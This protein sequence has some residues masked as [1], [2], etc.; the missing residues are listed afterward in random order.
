MLRASNVGKGS[1]ASVLFRMEL[2]G[3]P[4][5]LF[6][7]IQNRVLPRLNE[8]MLDPQGVSEDALESVAG[9]TEVLSAVKVRHNLLH[10]MGHTAKCRLEDNLKYEDGTGHCDGEIVERLHSSEHFFAYSTKRM[11]PSRRKDQLTA[12]VG[13]Q[14]LT[15]DSSCVLSLK[16]ATLRQRSKELVRNS[17]DGPITSMG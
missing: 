7:Y 15:I 8:L 13:L 14:N 6:R 16:H 17:A 11:R 12:F 2:S 1:Q 9:V 5:L 10:L 4:L 3:N